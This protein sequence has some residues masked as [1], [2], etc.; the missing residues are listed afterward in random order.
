MLTVQ[1]V[2]K[3]ESSNKSIKKSSQVSKV[4]REKTNESSKSVIGKP[5]QACDGVHSVPGQGVS[6]ANVG[7]QSPKK[8]L[9]TD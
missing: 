2:F 5:Q 7:F 6:T 3:R 4:I 1:K 9:L 8:H